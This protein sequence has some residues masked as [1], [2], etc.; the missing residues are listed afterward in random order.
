MSFLTKAENQTIGYY[1]LSS[2]FQSVLLPLLR[3]SS[4]LSSNSSHSAGSGHSSGL[5][6]FKGKV[7]LRYKEKGSE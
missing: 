7:N 3:H 2:F 4:S 1:L 6:G 5:G